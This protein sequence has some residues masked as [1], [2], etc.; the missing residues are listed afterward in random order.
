MADDDSKTMDHAKTCMIVC[1]IGLIATIIVL[2]TVVAV[3]RKQSAMLEMMSNVPTIVDATLVYHTNRMIT[4]GILSGSTLAGD[5]IDQKK[6]GD[7]AQSSSIGG[8]LNQER[9][10]DLEHVT[11]AKDLDV[12]KFV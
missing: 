10:G 8:R 9:S 2:L 4:A 6:S 11:S 12:N 1:I 5:R 3:H 7:L